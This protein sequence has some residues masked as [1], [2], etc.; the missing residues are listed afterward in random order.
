M[1][2]SVALGLALEAFDPVLVTDG[3]AESL[4]E[5]PVLGHAPRIV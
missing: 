5:L 1:A 4:G 3:Q 2:L